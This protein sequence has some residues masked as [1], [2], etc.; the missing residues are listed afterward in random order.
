MVQI[1][2]IVSVIVCIASMA[3]ADAAWTDRWGETVPTWNYRYI[4]NKVSQGDQVSGG[5]FEGF[6]DV[7]S[8][9]D[10]NVFATNIQCIRGQAWPRIAEGSSEYQYN[11]P[12]YPISVDQYIGKRLANPYIHYKGSWTPRSSGPS[13][14]SSSSF[15]TRSL[16]SGAYVWLDKHQHNNQWPYTVEINIWNT[17]M[18]GFPPGAHR[19]QDR[20][21]DIDG[22]YDVAWKDNYPFSGGTFR[23]FYFNL[24]KQKAD[25]KFNLQNMYKFLKE[26]H[27]LDGRYYIVETDIAAERH[28][29]GDGKFTADIISMGRP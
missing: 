29:G 11:T 3:I 27:R 2:R 20:Y 21:H 12:G 13:L 14:P 1:G 15:S 6:V 25:M 26:K 24:I 18:G 4:A 5:N 16:Q 7:W 28:P 9:S 23:A 22:S 19:F 8:S 10:G 17:H